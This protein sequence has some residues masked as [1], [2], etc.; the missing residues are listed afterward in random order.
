[1]IFSERKPS[2]SFSNNLIVPL[3]LI[4][5]LVVCL[6][7]VFQQEFM[8]EGYSTPTPNTDILAVNNPCNWWWG[9]KTNKYDFIILNASSRWG[10]PDPMVIK[11]MIALESGFNKTA[12]AWN[13]WCGSY[14]EGLMQVNPTCNDLNA[15]LL[16]KATYNINHGSY[17]WGENYF[18]LLNKWGKGCSLKYLVMGALEMYNLGSGGAGSTCGS[19]PKGTQYADAVINDYYF[20]FCND[21]NY[22]GRF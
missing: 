2:N 18:T 22:R 13:N 6:P 1:L 10:L 4:I 19:F 9:C 21:S 7:L 8:V 16:F 3:L 20:P 11:A 5:A 17:L 14:D 15:T 12:R